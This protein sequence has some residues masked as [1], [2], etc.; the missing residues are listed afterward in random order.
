[1]IGEGEKGE[2]VSGE[3]M[4]LSLQANVPCSSGDLQSLVNIA[5]YPLIGNFTI[6]ICINYIREYPL[7]ICT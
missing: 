2:H 3:T 6:A 5:K 1:M 4:T 7:I